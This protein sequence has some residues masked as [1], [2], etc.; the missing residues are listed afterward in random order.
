MNN[1]TSNENALGSISTFANEA[2]KAL[3][4]TLAVFNSLSASSVM[5]NHAEVRG[6]SRRQSAWPVN[7]IVQNSS[8]TTTFAIEFGCSGDGGFHRTNYRARWTN[9]TAE[10]TCLYFT[11]EGRIDWQQTTP[12]QLD[13]FA[14]EVLLLEPTNY[15]TARMLIEAYHVLL[16]S[17]AVVTHRP[18]NPDAA[19]K[20]EWRPAEDVFRHCAEFTRGACDE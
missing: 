19:T 17:S 12:A 14:G 5:V 4:D 10:P 2:P 18:I 6:Y 7:V 1:N 3:T 13:K 8:K 20:R 9:G 16:V 11:E 15:A